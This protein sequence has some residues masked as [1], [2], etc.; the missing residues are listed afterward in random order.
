M[1]L[2][3]GLKSRSKGRIATVFALAV[4]LVAV[5]ILARYIN[6]YGAVAAFRPTIRKVETGIVSYK[7]KNYFAVESDHFVLRYREV[8]EST[9]N[10]ILLTAEDKYKKLVDIFDYK[11]DEKI[12]VIVYN[13]VNTMMNTTMLRGDRAPMGVYFGNSLHIYNPIFWVDSS[14]D[15]ESVFYKE[16]PI[17]HELAHKFT[18]HIGRGNF[19]IWFTEGVSL[20]LEYEVDD[21]I[22]GK[23]L[24][25]DESIYSLE[26][27]TNMFNQLDVYSSYTQSFR[28]VKSYV[29]VNGIESLIK[30]IEDLGKGK[31]IDM[32]DFM[33]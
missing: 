27:L 22:W 6:Q 3:G 20:Y 19:P 11:F 12:Q 7:T 16:G 29:D 31:K 5:F 15:L 28:L 13:D 10:M 33:F 23:G 30:M 8:D 14:E 18:D 17:L 24:E 4:I 21:Y 25:I 32:N 1:P 26:N 2:L 9:V